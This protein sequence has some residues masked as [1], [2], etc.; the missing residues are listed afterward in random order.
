M[1]TNTPSD[2]HI[3]GFGSVSGGRYN[4][5]RIIGRGKITG[6]TTCSELV[7]NGS[8]EIIGRIDCHQMHVNGTADLCG[9]IKATDI[10]VRG[11][12]DVKN[13]VRCDSLTVSGS[14][15]VAGSLVAQN[16]KISGSCKVKE[17]LTAEAFSSTGRFEIGGLLNA[18]NVEVHLDWSTSRV[19]EIGGQN[20]TVMNGTNGINVLS[21]VTLGTHTPRLNADVIEGDKIILENT[22][23]RVVR[24]NNITV[25]D[26]CDVGLVEYKGTLYKSGSARVGQEKKV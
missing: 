18:E 1:D 2:L 26:G 20:I 9:D 22:H 16:V 4:V 8:G 14:A 5:V 17:D 13:G 11:T 3:S 10:K 25:G 12:A 24:G 19:R 6:D 7:I 15:N 21:I 23:A